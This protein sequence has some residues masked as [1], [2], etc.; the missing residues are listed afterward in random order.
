MLKIGEI[1][2]NTAL[3]RLNVINRIL[4]STDSLPP[5]CV[6]RK[7]YFSSESDS[8]NKNDKQKKTYVR[9]GN[10]ISEI[11][12]TNAPEKIP[13]GYLSQYC[14]VLSDSQSYLKLLKWLMQKDQLKQGIYFKI[15]I[16]IKKCFIYYTK[17]RFVFDWLSSRCFS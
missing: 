15:F 1:S 2:S 11:K 10:T 8:N 6:V 14:G 13:R 12:P 3:R 16:N 17:I 5:F 9:I 4:N 7:S